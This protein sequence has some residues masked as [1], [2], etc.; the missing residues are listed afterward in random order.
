H[1][2]VAHGLASLMKTARSLFPLISGLCALVCL[3]LGCA[4]N[5]H[6]GDFFPPTNSLQIGAAEI[7]ITPPVGHRMAGYFDER[8]S[9]GIHDPLKAKAIIL[10]QDKEQIAMVFCDL[11]GVSLTITT[12]ARAIASQ[13]TGIP[14]PNIVI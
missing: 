4:T 1:D 3:I 8:L 14:V 10:Q 13:K 7:D 9:T 5:S 6:P 12:N 11:V 2:A